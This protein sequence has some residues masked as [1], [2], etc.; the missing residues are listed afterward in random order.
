MNY[1]KA[2]EVNASGV[3]SINS[4]ETH[5]V[6]NTNI[7]G[8]LHVKGDLVVDGNITCTGNV[9]VNGNIHCDNTIEADVDVIAAGI[10]LVNHVHGGV[11][12]GGSKT[13]PPE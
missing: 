4:P 5:V 11:T 13:A 3:T 9:Q 7:V 12:G 1:T 6:G 8:N 2:L 10:S